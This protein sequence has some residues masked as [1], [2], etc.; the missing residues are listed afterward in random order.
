MNVIYRFN[1]RVCWVGAL[2]LLVG[3]AISLRAQTVLL[4]FGDDSS[5]RGASTVN[6]DGN[7][8]YWNNIHTGMFFPG[9]I[10]I[11]NQPTTINFGF[12][13]PVATDSYNGPAGPTEAIPGIPASNDPHFFV[14][15]TDIDQPALGTMGGSLAAAFD[16]VAGIDVPNFA[17]KFEIQAL[18]PAKKYDLSFFGSHKFSTDDTSV[19]SVYSDNTYTTLVGTTNLKVE[20]SADHSLHN[21][22]TVATITGLSPQANNILYVSF[23]GSNGNNGYLNE[24]QITAEAAAPLVGDYNADGKVDAADYAVWRKYAGTTHVLPND[25]T[26]GMIGPAQYTTW[27]TN[28]GSG[29]P[30]SGSG[31]GLGSA[32]PEPATLSL[33]FLGAAGLIATRRR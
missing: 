33:V 24:L 11:H 1:L 17:V 26:G 8:N 16:F 25:P 28:F 4:D 3:Q 22:D 2:A 23:I 27:R 12:S 13:T 31:L 21:R 15:F 7:G 29:G 19:Y 20:N 9:L 30:G 10:D 6:P 32:I 5:F 18:D 14:P